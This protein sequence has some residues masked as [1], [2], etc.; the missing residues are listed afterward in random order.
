MCGAV[1]LSPLL[2]LLLL[3]LLLLLC[4]HTDATDTCGASMQSVGLLL[5]LRLYLQARPLLLLHSV[6]LTQLLAGF[7]HRI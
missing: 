4:V 2:P 6:L 3:L 1:L 7:H 5:A